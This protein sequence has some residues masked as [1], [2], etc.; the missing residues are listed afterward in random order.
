MLNR[1]VSRIKALSG[2]DLVCGEKKCN[3]SNSVKV[4]TNE[5]PLVSSDFMT[6]ISGIL[7]SVGWSARYYENVSIFI[8]KQTPID[9]KV[10][11]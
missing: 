1:W 9:L 7:I 3:K 11:L 2:Q 4:K 6:G 8:N 10:V 5:K